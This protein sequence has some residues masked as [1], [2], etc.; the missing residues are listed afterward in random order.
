MFYFIASKVVKK[1]LDVQ[2]ELDVVNDQSYE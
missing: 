2:N 1:F